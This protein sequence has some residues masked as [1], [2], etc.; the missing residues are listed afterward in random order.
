MCHLNSYIFLPEAMVI[1]QTLFDFPV[2]YLC[3]NICITEG[4]TP[5]QDCRTAWAGP[6]FASVSGFLSSLLSSILAEQNHRVGCGDGGKCGVSLPRVVT[7]SV[8]AVCHSGLETFNTLDFTF[9]SLI[10][11]TNLRDA[12]VHTCPPTGTVCKC[13]RVWPRLYKDAES[14][15]H[16]NLFP[17]SGAPSIIEPSVSK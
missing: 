2:S 14:E 6:G 7:L 13:H 9:S 15:P 5:L 8:A 3:V 12:G 16:T 10:L 4:A 1:K 11:G 17:S